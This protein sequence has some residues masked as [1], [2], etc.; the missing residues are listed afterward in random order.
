MLK[1]YFSFLFVLISFFAFAS[2]SEGNEPSDNGGNKTEG[3]DGGVTPEPKPET[4]I[5]LVLV[6]EE[7]RTKDVLTLN[8]GDT[9]ELALN[10]YGMAEPYLYIKNNTDE[11]GKVYI[12]ECI[13]DEGMFVGTCY[14]INGVPNCYPDVVEITKQHPFEIPAHGKFTDGVENGT[15]FHFSFMSQNG[16]IVKMIFMFDGKEEEYP[17]YFNVTK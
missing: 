9:C 12:N 2:C 4:A 8:A 17:F 7:D 5:A 1:N 3:G 6:D 15:N 10:K 13:S 14:T 16:G 11:D